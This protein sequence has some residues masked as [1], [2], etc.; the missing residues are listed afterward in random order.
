VNNQHKHGGNSTIKIYGTTRNPNDVKNPNQV[1]STRLN[2]QTHKQ[3]IYTSRLLSYKNLPEPINASSIFAV[4][5]IT[6]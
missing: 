5:N 3:A 1:I 4:E 2:Y 6:N